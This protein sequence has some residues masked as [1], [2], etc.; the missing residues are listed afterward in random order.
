MDS[1]LV[2]VETFD[3]GIEQRH[4]GAGR[5]DG[6]RRGHRQQ[7]GR[8]VGVLDEGSANTPVGR[9]IPFRVGGQFAPDA[10]PAHVAG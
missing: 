2:V 8:D 3:A 5:A 10:G 9:Q 1:V 4:D 7:F 6:E